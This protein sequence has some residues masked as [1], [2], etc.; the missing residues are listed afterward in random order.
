MWDGVQ[1]S[2]HVLGTASDIY[3]TGIPTATLLAYCQ[4]LVREGILGYTYTNN[5][6]MSGVVHINL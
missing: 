1:G 3:I 2:K 4:S 6:N 5:S